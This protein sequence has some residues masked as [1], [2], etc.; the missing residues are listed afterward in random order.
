MNELENNGA[1]GI[2]VCTLYI[3]G[4]AME[5]GEITRLLGVDPSYSH[6]YGD[7]IIS[8]KNK[9]FGPKRDS[10]WAFKIV[11]EKMELNDL[12]SIFANECLI[13]HHK[14]KDNFNSIREIPNVERAFVDIACFSYDTINFIMCPKILSVFAEIGLEIEFTFDRVDP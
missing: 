8:K 7:V 1:A 4:K 10:V 12:I 2:S 14:L 13:L 5:P 6:R 9:K 11:K 3:C